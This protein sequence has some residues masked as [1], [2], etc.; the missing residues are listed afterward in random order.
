MPLLKALETVKGVVSMKRILSIILFFLLMSMAYGTNIY[1]WVDKDGVVNFADDMN[2]VPSIYRDK[3]EVRE[4]LSEGGTPIHL[5]ELTPKIIP[6]N[7]EELRVDIFGQDETYWK[8]KV[9]P[10]KERL[11]EA[12]ANYQKEHRQFMQKADELSEMRFGSPTQYKKKI[13]ELDGSKDEMTKYQ[14]QMAEAKEM[15]KKISKEAEGAKAD[16][17]WLK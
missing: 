17:E 1:K 11:K 12:T 13:I 3:A 5:Q 2:Q 7:K 6:K 15:L 9:R 16:P 4:Y 10:W 14:A 8:G